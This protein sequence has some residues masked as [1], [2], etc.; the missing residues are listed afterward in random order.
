VNFYLDVGKRPS[1]RHLLIRDE[2][3]GEFEP[4][5]AGWQVGPSY[6]RRR[7]TARSR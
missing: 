2:P 3:T 7:P 4:G 5:N 1:W 6:R